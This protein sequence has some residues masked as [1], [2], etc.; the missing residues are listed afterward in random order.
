MPTPSPLGD[1]GVYT[2]LFKKRSGEAGEKVDLTPLYLPHTLTPFHILYYAQQKISTN[3]TQQK[4]RCG[5]LSHLLYYTATKNNCVLAR[6]KR[7][8][9]LIFQYKIE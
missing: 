9:A 4:K 7:V 5:C 3:T 2:F 1:G 8:K 6:N